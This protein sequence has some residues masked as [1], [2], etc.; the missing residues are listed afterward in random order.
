ML[1]AC[2]DDAPEAEATVESK[3]TTKSTDAPR[4]SAGAVVAGDVAALLAA[5]HRSHAEIR[6]DTGPHRLRVHTSFDLSPTGDPATPEPAVEEKRPMPQHVDDELELLWL[7]TQ[8]NAPRFSLTQSN[9]HDRGRDVIV[10]GERVFTRQR[11][12][13]WFVGPVQSDVFELWL[14]DAQRSVHDVVALAAVQLAVSASREESTIVLTLSRAAAANPG[15]RVSDPRAAWRSK[16]QVDAVAGTITLDATTLAWVTAKLDVS[17]SVPGP[18]GR[19]LA[20]SVK[21][22]AAREAVAGDTALPIPA[23]AQVQPLQERSRYDAERARLLD[24]L[25]GG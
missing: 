23:E 2:G 11:N 22:D 18:D 10:D 16:A 3:A 9:E 19:T 8:V 20:G 24:G 7:T 14:D 6:R 4:V 13:T 15:L 21:I 5:L 25:A 1:S 12:R 17:Y